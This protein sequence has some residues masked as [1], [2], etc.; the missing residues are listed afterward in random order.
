MERNETQK[1]QINEADYID[2][3]VF[4]RAFLRLARRYL[5]LVCPMILCLTAG[6]SLLSR[7]LVKEQYIAETTFV[8]GVTL[9][10]DLSYNYSLSGVRDD[11]VMQMP[12]SFQSVIHSDY[13]YYL[14]EE[15]LGQIIPGEI[16]WVNV[17]GTN[18]GG[19]NVVS[20]S[21]K[22]AEQLRDA[23]VTCLPKALFT[24]LGDIEL[25]IQGTSERTE[26]IH[27]E[28]SSPLIWGGAGVIGGIFA[29]L[30]IIFLIT[31]WRHDIETS[32]DMAEI[33][34]LPCL[35]SLPKSGKKLS[36]KELKNSRSR[37]T[38]D[39]Y[40]RA[41]SDFRKQLEDI[42]EQQPLRTLLFTGEFKKRGQTTLLD[43]LTN[44]WTSQGKKVQC[45][46][47]P[48][49]KVQRTAIQIQEELNH[50]I[51]ESLKESDLVIINGPDYG[52][53]VEL[54]S[55]ADCVDGLVYIVKAGYDQM[56]STK[57]AVCSLGFTQ[58]KTLGYVIT[59]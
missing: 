4:I 7:A 54:L 51:E 19:I 55:A 34:D 3:T 41:F 48:L 1:K 45:I 6:I 57:E 58:A 28:V 16:N 56:E 43:K 36:G 49:S 31:L 33:T 52:Q 26:V 38:D 2:I 53:T 50:Q 13:M 20:D 9:S 30:G 46:N 29:Y 47:V 37:N 10:D 22:N 40:N 5:L 27:E 39:E 15:E 18:I 42:M 12:E 24:T 25:K 8:I 17:Y 11:Y 23:V 32:E 59:V 21:M 44:D 14:L 35:G